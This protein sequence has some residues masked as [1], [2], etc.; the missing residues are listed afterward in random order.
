MAEHF[1]NLVR[2]LD[3]QV[4]EDHRSTNKFELKVIPSKTHYNKPAKNQR[5]RENLKSSKRKEAGN[6]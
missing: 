2:Y 1:P 4:Q 5:Q 6:S 3:I